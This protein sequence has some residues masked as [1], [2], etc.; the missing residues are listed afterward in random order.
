MFDLHGKHGE[1]TWDARLA[2]LLLVQS[3]LGLLAGALLAVVVA[4]L[5]LTPVAV[6]IEPDGRHVDKLYHFV[7]FAALVF[8]VIA[9]APRRWVWAA[10][11]AVAFGGAIELIQPFVNREAEWLDFLANN[12]GVAAGVWAG[13]RAHQWMHERLAAARR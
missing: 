3:W 8:P 13:F 4:Y 2:R 1:Q 6:P 12:L 7:A 10:P 11:L 5:T 9:T